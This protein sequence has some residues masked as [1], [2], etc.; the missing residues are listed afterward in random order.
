MVETARII[1]N[2]FSKFGSTLF[3]P[4]KIASIIA[5]TDTRNKLRIICMLLNLSDFINA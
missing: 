1:M 3:K 2:I 5:P 4:N